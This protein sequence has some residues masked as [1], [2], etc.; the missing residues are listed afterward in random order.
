MDRRRG[1]GQRRGVRRAMTT[2]TLALTASVTAC[3]AANPVPPA[4]TPPPAVTTQQLQAVVRAAMADARKRSGAKSAKLKVITAEPVT[5]G[6]GSLGCP[7]EGRN[8]T[9]ALVPGFRVRIGT[10]TS[11]WLEYHAGRDGKPVYCPPERI[12]PPVPDSGI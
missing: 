4:E 2:A 10:D 7:E 12:V 6:D 8:Y 1:L 9:D 3:L 11:N 5:W